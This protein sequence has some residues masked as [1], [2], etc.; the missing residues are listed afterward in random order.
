MNHLFYYNVFFFGNTIK[1]LERDRALTTLAHTR[2]IL[3]LCVNHASTLFKRT[4]I[5]LL[6]KHIKHKTLMIQTWKNINWRN[7]KYDLWYWSALRKCEIS[8]KSIVHFLSLAPYIDISLRFGQCRVQLYRLY[9]SYPDLPA[10]FSNMYA[11]LFSIYN[12]FISL[13]SEMKVFIACFSCHEQVPS[14]DLLC[15]TWHIGSY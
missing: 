4:H 3:L 13:S 11:S 1:D 15:T 6:Q 5:K 12:F 8:K 2:F 9:R 7:G 14:Y 10:K